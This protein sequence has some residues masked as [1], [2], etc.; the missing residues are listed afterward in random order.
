VLRRAG[1]AT[2]DEPVTA[3]DGLEVD[4]SRHTVTRDGE[5]V[6]LTPT[7]FDL[8]RTLVRNRGRLMT[9]RTLLTEV[10][11]PGYE[12]DTQVLRVHVA[13]LRRKLE[14]D[15]GNPYWIRTDPGIGYR[16]SE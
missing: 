2:A 15:P 9:H 3:A 8:L 12:H 10:W 13:N 7:E 1:T 14:R 4:L 16:F 11:G 6:H 5:E